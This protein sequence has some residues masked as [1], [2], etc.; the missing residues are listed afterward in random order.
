MIICCNKLISQHK[1]SYTSTTPQSGFD[2]H[3]NSILPSCANP[4]DPTIHP[5]PRCL[6][7]TSLHQ[8]T[9]NVEEA[10]R[11][12]KILGTATDDRFKLGAPCMVSLYIWA[13]FLMRPRLK[14]TSIKLAWYL[15]PQVSSLTE[16]SLAYLFVQVT[17]Q[18]IR[19]EKEKSQLALD[20]YQY[21]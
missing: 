16:T 2:H 21:V 10:G 11:S 1:W 13:Y 15:H 6:W 7:H 8:V 9:H 14:R 5:P 19:K 17:T 18:I 20:S 3:C 4:P 12:Q